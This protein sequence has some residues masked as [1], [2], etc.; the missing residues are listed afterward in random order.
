[1]RNTLI[2]QRQPARPER[3]AAGIFL[4]AENEIGILKST[5]ILHDRTLGRTPILG[6]IPKV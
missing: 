5:V 6:C 1:M 4:H 3:L 2:G